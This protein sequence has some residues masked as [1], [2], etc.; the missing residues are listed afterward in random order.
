MVGR[1]IQHKQIAAFCIL[2]RHQ[3]A[4]SPI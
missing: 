4:H 3:K 2:F 1:F